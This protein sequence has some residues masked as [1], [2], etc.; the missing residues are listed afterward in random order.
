VKNEEKIKLPQQLNTAK[1]IFS[2]MNI[3]AAVLLLIVLAACAA[4]QQAGPAV[5]QQPYIEWK[6]GECCLD[7]NNNLICDAD[8]PVIIPEQKVTETSPTQMTVVEDLL[9][10]VPKEYSFHNFKTGVVINYNNKRRAFM[11]PVETRSTSIYW[12]L[13][14][15]RGWIVCDSDVETRQL[16]E[17]YDT[18]VARCTPGQIDV[19]EM[20]RTEYVQ[21]LDIADGPVDWMMRYKDR[22]PYKVETQTQQL[23][24]RSISPVA[25]YEES[26]GSITALKFDQYYKVPVR[27]EKIRNINGNI[28]KTVI[29]YEFSKDY[30]GYPIT[31]SMVEPPEPRVVEEELYELEITHMYPTNDKNVRIRGFLTNNAEIKTGSSRIKIECVDKYGDVIGSDYIFMGTVQPGRTESFE[32]DVELNVE[33][34]KDCHAT[35]EDYVWNWG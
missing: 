2:N 35:A 3:K 11:D 15:Q 32:T 25:Y 31:P 7:A 8:E 16:G 13:D 6:A 26:D 9:Q 34:L 27:I 28:E 5:C 19:R 14:A 4:E 33:D 18:D 22:E 10:Y 20:T 1:P 24:Y 29:N 23:G 12:N 30:E 21:N 17:M